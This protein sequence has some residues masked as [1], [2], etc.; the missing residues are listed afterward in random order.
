MSYTDA[1]RQWLIITVVFD[2]SRVISTHQ[3][4]SLTYASLDEKSNAL[5]RGLESVGVRVGDRVGVMLGNSV[6][7]SIVRAMLVPCCLPEYML[8]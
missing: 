3:N 8:S 4:A 7:Y 5:A 2:Y 1:Y 6:E